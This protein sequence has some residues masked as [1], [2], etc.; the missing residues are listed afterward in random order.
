M[1]GELPAELLVEIV[2]KVIK[3]ADISRLCRVS[4]RLY[5]ISLPLLYES[6]TLS[7][8]ELSLTSLITTAEKLPLKH[9]KYTTDICI[10]AP[11]RKRLWNRCLHH[12][13]PRL[14]D[15]AVLHRVDNCVED[16]ED[17]EFPDRDPFFHAVTILDLLFFGLAKNKL[18]SFSWD[19][20]TCI[21]GDL[22][23]S[24]DSLLKQ[25]TRIETI[26]IITDS[27][28]GTN[29][30]TQYFVDFT[31]LTNLRSLSWKGLQRFD[32]FNSVGKFLSLNGNGIKALTLDLLDWEKAESIWFDDYKRR[33][34]APIPDNFFAKKVLGV[35]SGEKKTLLQSLE[36]LSLLALSFES[37]IPEMACSFNMRNLHTLKLWNCPGSLDLLLALV[38]DGTDTIQYKSFELVLDL[39]T[40]WS[41]GN[42]VDAAVPVATFLSGFCG[43]EDLYLMLPPS[44]GW[45]IITQ[46]ILCH[47]STLRRLAI[48][49]QNAD[50][51][52]LAGQIKFSQLF[53]DTNLR[54]IGISIPAHALQREWE[55]LV[56]RPTCQIL[57]IRITGLEYDR[58]NYSD[59]LS[60]STES[61]FNDVSLYVSQ[62]TNRGTSTS[63]ATSDSEAL[64]RDSKATKKP[65]SSAA[66]M[67][68]SSIVFD[69]VRKPA[70]ESIEDEAGQD[71]LKFARWASSSDGLQNLQVIAW[72]NFSYEGRY[73]QD[74]V[75]LCR[76]GAEFRP[77]TV[78]D[79]Y[80][81]D[82]ININMDMLATCPF[83]SILR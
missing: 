12:D 61:T 37:A 33:V 45:N 30:E 44:L 69:E 7:A 76:K 31:P 41:Q 53:E 4:K 70:T 42:H 35:T 56:V 55:R 79:T 24:V 28:C 22:L 77:L 32:D 71:I 15:R 78:A 60:D 43:L 64:E 73:A 3:K 6:I 11:F 18:R 13:D 65:P 5:Q 23:F 34:R 52:A 67:E 38:A 26:S 36:D 51:G 49:D 81:W 16:D 14:S 1:L 40:F 68:M 20:G 57:H 80:F 66:A 47:K 50:E 63:N 54:C 72:G 58:S 74:N 19:L 2:R 83:D 82:L 17:D 9:L 8:T 10:T 48:D 25:Q 27:A 39:H 62:A 29:F 75:L 46:S 21:P 59:S